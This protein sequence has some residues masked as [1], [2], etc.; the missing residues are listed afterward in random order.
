MKRNS[1]IIDIWI[2]EEELPVRA[3]L[4]VIRTTDPDFGFSED[5][6]A[7]RN[8][9]IRCYIQRDFE[10]L[11]L[12]PELNK[13]DGFFIGD[14]TPRDD[15]YSAFNTQDFQKRLAPFDSYGYAIR[16]IMERIKDL[17]ILH[18]SISASERRADIQIKYE[19]LVENQ[20]RNRLSAYIDRYRITGDIETKMFLKRKIA[21][22]NRRIQECKKIWEQYAPWDI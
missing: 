22:S 2:P 20:F 13:E 7:D 3:G 11:M 6:V 21:E 5:E 14:F 8:E 12:L 19:V 10:L 16:K 4:K 18:S 15:E 1:S 9:F 17:A